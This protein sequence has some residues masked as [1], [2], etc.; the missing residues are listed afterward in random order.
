M[1][2]GPHVF[3][4]RSHV[5]SIP[6]PLTVALDTHR[7]AGR[8]LLDLTGSN[9]TQAGFTY[10]EDRIVR[11]LSSRNVLSYEPEPFGLRSARALVA[12]TTD[13]SRVLLTA[14][15]SEAYSFLFK[16]LCNAGDNVL[17][18]S[19]SYP[20]FT[21]LATLEHVQVTPYRLVF[22]GRWHVDLDDV[23][24]RITP[25]TRAIIVVN[26]NNPTGS[27]L[28]LAE[29]Q[30]LAALGLPIISDEVFAPYALV[31]DVTRAHTALLQQDVLTFVLSGLSKFAGLP[32]MKLGWTV[33][34]G[35]PA[36]VQEALHRLELI[37]DTF[38]SVG[39]PVQHALSTFLEEGRTL[40]HQIQQRTAQNVHALKA[41]VTPEDPVSVLHV[42]G[43]W[44]VPLRLPRV[45]SDEQWALL[46]LDAGV[47]TQPG[48]FYD[49]EQ[50]GLL[51]L[52]LLTPP[53]LFADGVKTLVRRVREEC[54]R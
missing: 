54:A 28:K 2:D 24:A 21:H 27:F 32:Q 16:L 37:A 25:A 52:S 6:N 11:A 14:S 51:V 4:A 9:P 45:H 7:A 17:V 46:L 47:L 3:S 18:P 41:L 38:L 34:G 20:L 33:V 35:P 36:R 39:A 8:P 31:E 43:G 40:Q 53:A 19:P 15:T 29:L 10:A 1:P 50:D 42:E 12:P 44:T 13:P 5:T 22:D 26:P 23:R 48:Y 30:A 49:F